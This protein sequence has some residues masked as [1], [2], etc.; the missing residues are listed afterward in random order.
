MRHFFTGLTL[1]LIGLAIGLPLGS[2][3]DSNAGFATDGAERG[4]TDAG[5]SK[6]TSDRPHVAA[7]D[8]V[9]P[10]GARST[11]ELTADSRSTVT[12][13]AASFDAEIARLATRLSDDA[14][15][16]RDGVITGRVLDSDGAPIA[17]ADVVLRGPSPWGRTNSR[18]VDSASV[19][20]S[21]AESGATQGQ[22][23]GYLESLIRGSASAASLVTGAQGSFRAEGLLPGQYTVSVYAED[24]VFDPNRGGTGDKLEFIGHPVLTFELEVVMPDGTAPPEAT[25]VLVQDQ[26]R[27]T[28]FRWTPES[29][30]LRVA[31]PTTM[32]Q[33]LC[34]R[35]V[36]V[37]NSEWRADAR[38]EIR[39]LD[40]A[41]DGRGPHLFEL[42]AYPSV[43]IDVTP[44]PDAG[45][46]FE[47]W[48]DLVR[49]ETRTPVESTEAGVF[50]AYDITSGTYTVEV[51]RGDGLAEESREVTVDVGR[52]DVSIELGA[53]DES[54][55]L[56]I[57]CHDNSGRPVMDI[58]S[59]GIMMSVGGT[60]VSTSSLAKPRANGEYW[61]SIERDLHF[62]DVLDRSAITSL[63]LVARSTR[64]GELTKKI[65]LEANRVEL[66]F[67]ERCDLVVDVTGDIPAGIVAFVEVPPDEP[68]VGTD[69]A[70]R[71]R[72]NPWRRLGQRID[73]PGDGSVAFSALPVGVARVVLAY[74]NTHGSMHLT[75]VDVELRA[76]GNRAQI[77]APELC[78]FVVLVPGGEGQI[79][80]LMKER[81]GEFVRE[82]QVQAKADE[83]LV[84]RNIAAGRYRVSKRGGVRSRSADYVVPCGEVVFEPDR[85]VGYEVVAIREGSIAEQI[86]LRVGDVLVGVD[87]L[88]A[89]AENFLV[90]FTSRV[91]RP[92]GTTLVLRQGSGR[93]E[94][95]VRLDDPPAR[96]ML[97]HGA[98]FE[99]LSP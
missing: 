23:L 43:H 2:R 47:P 24:F 89:E 56:I 13:S 83:R 46:P 44:S 97:G 77:E 70:G 84:F 29:P 37:S 81:N 75:H 98:R 90:E 26:R 31:S 39:R 78:E 86:G 73:V 91:A 52:V 79:F 22:G 50:A 38:S 14:D 74:R 58:R 95:A 93:S 30:G 8:S 88:G 57:Q 6:E 80:V 5:P 62:Q 18:I 63:T 33:V 25:V 45:L 4:A 9:D 10:R 85:I 66:L 67:E 41:T 72:R 71:P 92:E 51:G 28:Q 12:R 82:T 76:G 3:M 94:L 35:V 65:D 69:G 53:L 36:L 96:S 68:A 59:F 15:A 55:F 7:I 20:R 49:G 60:H 11:G 19:G 87:H 27:G 1:L 34:G 61:L 17:G 54:R 21:Y 64:L 48:C 99:A 42:A 40:F 32:V 16:A